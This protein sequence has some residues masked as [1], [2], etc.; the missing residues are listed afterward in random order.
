MRSQIAN[1]LKKRCKAIRNA[2]NAYN[3]AADAFDPPRPHANWQKVAKYEFIEEFELL[4]QTGTNIAEKEFVEPAAREMIKIW[5]RVARAREEV[6]RCQVETRRLHTSIR[7]EEIHFNSVLSTMDRGDP[8]YQ[9][10]EDFCTRRL[11]INM[12]LL[13]RIQ[14]IYAVP[15]YTGTKGPGTR[16]SGSPSVTNHPDRRSAD[17]GPDSTLPGPPPAGNALPGA[18]PSLAGPINAPPTLR[19]LPGATEIQPDDG[20]DSG[21]EEDDEE[22]QMSMDLMNDWTGRLAT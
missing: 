4:K 18:D 13:M 17:P 5:R 6:G 22:A 9:A 7:D 8:L 19:N 16:L 1:S 21:D 3:K 11:R 14:Q 20:E 2:V 12:R 10:V 15:I